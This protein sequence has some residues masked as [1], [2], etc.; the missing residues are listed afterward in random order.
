M[1]Y[2]KVFEK[3]NISDADINKL[4][5]AFASRASKDSANKQP[6]GIYHS[7]AI[8]IAMGAIDMSEETIDAMSNGH[9]AKGWIEILTGVTL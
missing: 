2:Q 9:T 4:V 5:D 3:H 7:A 1:N 8:D 6:D